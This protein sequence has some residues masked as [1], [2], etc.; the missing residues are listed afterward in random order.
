MHEVL[1]VD[2]YN[3]R[4]MLRNIVKKGPS[5][6]FTCISEQFDGL[7]CKLTEM[8]EMT[9]MIGIYRLRKLRA[10]LC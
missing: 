6:L 3:F 7:A 1:C 9:E 5:F 2:D 4:W 10:V 8:N